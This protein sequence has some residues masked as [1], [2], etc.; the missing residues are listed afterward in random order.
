MTRR[1]REIVGLANEQDFPHMVELALAPQA[2][3]AAGRR[4]S[5]R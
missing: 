1:K 3:R 5:A 2:D 4:R